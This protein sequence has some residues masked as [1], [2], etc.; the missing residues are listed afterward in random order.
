MAAEDLHGFDRTQVLATSGSI[1]QD[2]TFYVLTLLDTEPSVASDTTLSSMASAR[3]TALSD[4][5]SA[6]YDDATCLG[7]AAKWSDTDIAAAGDAMVA[8]GSDVPS[9]LRNSGTAALHAAGSDAELLRAA[10]TDAANALNK[11][12]DEYVAPLSAA[13]RHAMI[14]AA[15]AGAAGQPCYRPL[16]S[17]VLA[18][19]DA[20]DR[21]EATRYEPLADGEN[22]VA[23]ARIP[24]IDFAKFPFSVIVVPGKG[25]SDLDHAL[26]PGG[27]IRADQAAARF[28]AGL[29]PLIALSGGHVHPDRTPY[30]EAIEMKKYLMNA[31][32]IQ[33]DAILVDPH[34]RHTT[35]NLRNVGRQLYRYGVP[36]DRPALVTSDFLQTLYIAAASDTGIFGKRCLDELGY[37][38]WR[39]ITQLDELDDCWIPAVTSLHQDGRD[40]LDP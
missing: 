33:E 2:K 27:Q 12:W 9:R 36:T 20:A 37:K 6:C 10:W 3:A 18:G 30:S 5:L 15:L 24:A 19:L 29:A 31:H 7:T 28:Q 23:I 17:L 13:D 4:A 1:E 39:G 22:A 21:D 32:A 38:P 16:L 26:D 34:A 35:T 8:L 40:L 11:G 25:P 14:Q